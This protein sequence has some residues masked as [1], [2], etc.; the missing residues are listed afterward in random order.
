MAYKRINDSYVNGC[1]KEYI[2]DTDADFANLPEACTGSMAVS[3]E[4]G[5]VYVVNT[6]GEW[7][8]FGA[9]SG[10]GGSDSI[11]GTWV[12]RDE[13]NFDDLTLGTEYSI[14]CTYTN[15]EGVE[16][17]FTT[18]RAN[19]RGETVTELGYGEPKAYMGGAI[20]YVSVYYSDI[21]AGMPQGW[22]DEAYK[23]ITILEEPSDA[24]FITWLKANAV[25][26]GA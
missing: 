24:E 1:R 3:L 21:Y 16:A 4:S 14:S 17:Q 13:L 23:T 19:L 7:V 15:P 5:K 25:K 26:Q 2:C 11:V 9:S 8:E 6:Q 12:F 22:G 10:G 20:G 18:I